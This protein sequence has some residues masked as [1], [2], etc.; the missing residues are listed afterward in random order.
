MMQE[1]LYPEYFF[2][3]Q[4]ISIVIIEISSKD[5]ISQLGEVLTVLVLTEAIIF[6]R[7][8]L[9]DVFVEAK[10]MGEFLYE[11]QPRIGG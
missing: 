4:F 11:K 10:L 7:Y 6:I 5:L 8:K 3:G 9:A 2:I 1:P